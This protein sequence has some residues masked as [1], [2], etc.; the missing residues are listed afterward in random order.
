[1]LK[2]L[3]T[4]SLALFLV[5]SCFAGKKETVSDPVMPDV[6]AR[7]RALF[8]YDQAAWHATDALLATKPPA[9]SAG[10]YIARKS[11]TGWTVAFG[12]LSDTG[13]KFLVAYEAVQGAT[14]QEFAV[15]RLD[16]PREDTSFYLAA[17]KAIDTAL[18]DFR[19]E[20]RPYNVA[21]LPTAP[22]GLYVYV[23]PAQTET[24]IY[25]L[26]GD[27]RYIVTSD[28]GT[29]VDKR[30]LHKAIIE[31]SPT[32]IP[33][34]TTPAGGYHTHVLSDVP[35]DTD[36]FFVLTR[37]PSEPEFIGMKNK[38][39]YEISPDGTIRETKM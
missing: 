17:A 4:L 6:T 25:P 32:S 15:K 38:K 19:G 30:Q 8:E 11:D 37:Q 24:G 2:R 31:I 14:L 35:E 3:G 12:H 28:G 10:R 33:K 27:V 13:D 7:G 18:H 20:K 22:E 9:Q 23:V 26:G 29:I 36:V 1:M 39:V 5:S 21:V 34:G 16:P